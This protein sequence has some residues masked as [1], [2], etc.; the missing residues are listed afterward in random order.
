M[1]HDDV[2]IIKSYFLWGQH[3]LCYSGQFFLKIFNVKFVWMLSY[4]PRHEKT[5][6][7]WFANN[8]GED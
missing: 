4:G 3:I 5:C 8:K 2:E 6:L 7:G 1:R